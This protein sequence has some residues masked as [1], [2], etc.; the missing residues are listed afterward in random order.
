MFLDIHIKVVLL[1]IDYKFKIN[2]KI[3]K[4]KPD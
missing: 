1:L 3:L 2:G 4:I